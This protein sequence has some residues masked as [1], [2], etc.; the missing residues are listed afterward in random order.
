MID[1]LPCGIRRV[2]LWTFYRGELCLWSTPLLHPQPVLAFAVGT[3]SETEPV[4][5]ATN[6][7]DTFEDMEIFR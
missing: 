4:S 2:L 5:L 1:A 6:D 3:R 7:G